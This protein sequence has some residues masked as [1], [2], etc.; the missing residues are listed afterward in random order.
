MHMST[1]AQG[2]HSGEVTCLAVSHCGTLVATGQRSA[3]PVVLVWSAATGA[4]VARLQ[5]HHAT[6]ITAL[7]FSPDGR[8][9]CTHIHCIVDSQVLL[10]Q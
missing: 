5:G 2:E 9:Y 4:T 1:Q 6:A 10:L 3:K 7:A 8:G